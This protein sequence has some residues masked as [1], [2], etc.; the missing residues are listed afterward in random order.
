MFPYFFLEQPFEQGIFSL[1]FEVK[2]TEMETS[3]KLFVIE[4]MNNAVTYK[5]PMLVERDDVTA[6]DAADV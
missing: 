1:R 3:P 6:A 5:V 4:A 2:A